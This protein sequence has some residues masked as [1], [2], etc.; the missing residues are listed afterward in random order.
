MPSIKAAAQ[1]ILKAVL[2]T[3]PPRLWI[4]LGLGG[5]AAAIL[6]V[7]IF[8]QTQN[9]R[10]VIETVDDSVKI[11]VESDG[12]V[13]IIDPKA[14]R[15]IKLWPG[16]YDVRLEDERAGLSLNTKSFTMKRHGEVVLEVRYEPA[17]VGQAQPDETLGAKA[18][19]SL[20][21]PGP[22][23]NVLPGIVQRPAVMSV[24]KRWQ[25]ETKLPRQDILSLAWSPDDRM[26]ACG[27]R[28]GHVRV[29]DAPTWNLVKLFLGH[30]KQVRCVAWHPDGKRLAACNTKIQIW[31]IDGTL[32][33]EYD[34][35]TGNVWSLVIGS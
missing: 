27:T 10:L 35:D 12:G 33:D 8:V 29:Y 3:V 20:W 19:E 28:T 6:G 4:A 11:L 1:Y 25:V 2:R 30:E 13:E 9:G 24:I 32:E 21:Q 7:V 23:H 16:E 31:S 15:T 34:F 17:Q 5:I 18:I 26:I 14:N 22:D